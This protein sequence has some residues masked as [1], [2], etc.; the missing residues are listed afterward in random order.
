MKCI[1]P[2][3]LSKAA[4]LLN[5]HYIGDPEAQIT[6]LNEIHMV[7]EGDIT[8]VDHPKYYDSALQSK[9]TFILINQEVEYPKGKG[10]IISSDP[11]IDFNRL[12][13]TYRR[14]VPSPAAISTTA[15]TGEGTIIQPGAFVGHHVRIGKRCIIHANAVLYDHTEIG[16]DTIIHANTVIGSDAFYHQ[17]RQNEVIKFES[18][19]RV[20]I[21]NHVEI[22]ACC[23]ID[24]GVTGDTVIGDY[25]RFDNNIHIGHDVKIGKR[26]LFAASVVVG[27]ITVIEDD[28][29]CWGQVAINKTLTIGKGAVILATSAVGKNLEGG[30]VYFGIPAVEARKKWRELALIQKLPEM[31]ASFLN[32][33]RKK[34]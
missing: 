4:S 30:K 16:D 31:Y 11:F 3:T 19:G 15:E 12:I 13:K 29:I 33:N 23:T 14:F 17:R 26:C 28:V 32:N 22:G 8:F 7:E 10:L 20:I 5:A 34:K 27:G 9:A 18:C 24:K 21:G 25:T 6:G 1:P 2:L